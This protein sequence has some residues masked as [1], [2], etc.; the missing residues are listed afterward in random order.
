MHRR[1]KKSQEKGKAVD[2]KGL[3][4]QDPR[5]TWMGGGAGGG[6]ENWLRHGQVPGC[7]GRPQSGVQRERAGRL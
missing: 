7:E 4:E 2:V 6:G 1:K 3:M 5:A